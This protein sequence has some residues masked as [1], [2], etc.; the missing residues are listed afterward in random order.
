ME[1]E[2]GCVGKKGKDSEGKVSRH[3]MGGQEKLRSFRPANA[4][5]KAAEV[6]TTTA[7]LL[8]HAFDKVTG[9]RVQVDHA[10]RSSV[11]VKDSCL[12]ES[13]RL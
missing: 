1:S 2:D 4:S 7:R 9:Q 12:P 3:F 11:F 10:E 8:P 6:C 13:H 5:P